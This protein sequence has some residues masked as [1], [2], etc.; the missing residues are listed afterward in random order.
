MYSANA[1]DRGSNDRLFVS[2]NGESLHRGG[3]EARFD[4][5]G[6]EAKEP[7]SELGKGSELKPTGDLDGAK[8][9]SVAAIAF[10]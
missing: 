3:S 7:W 8:R 2:D 1:F 10:V 4:G 6:L 5:S 9:A